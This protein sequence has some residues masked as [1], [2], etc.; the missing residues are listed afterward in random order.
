MKIKT[1]LKLIIIATISMLVWIICLQLWE[2]K[3]TAH[4]NRQEDSIRELS[5]DIFLSNQ[6]REE[7]FIYKTERAKQQWFALDKQ[8]TDKC[9]KEMLPLFTEASEKNELELFMRRHK[10]I[11]AL[12]KQLILY[13]QA[14]TPG[15]ATDEIRSIIINQMTGESHLQYQQC[16]LLSGAIDKM[17]EKQM[18]SYSTFNFMSLGLFG[19][20]IIM[21]SR[22]LL[23]R[24]SD[25]LLQ[26]KEGTRIISE[27]NFGHRLN[28]ASSDEIG[29]LARDF[30]L[31]TEQLSA[32]TVS[33]D[34]MSEEIENRKKAEQKL[35]DKNIEME[36]FAY[37]V[38]HDL[39]SPLITIQA[40][41]GMIMNNLE[42]GKHDCIQDDM[43]RIEGAA[44]KMTNLLNDLLELSRVGVVMS[45]PA[46]IDMNLLVKDCL[47]LLT[48]PLKQKGVEVVVQP[49][50]PK[51]NGDRHRIT[52]VL[53]NLVE[54]AVKYMGEQAAPRIL[55]GTREN[56]PET[57]F[58]VAD[59]GS[60][61][62]PQHHD[63]IFGLFNKLDVK[64]QGTGVGLALVK[65]IIEVHGGRVWVE[66][67]GAGKG[68]TFC[69]TVPG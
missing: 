66:S 24:V 8:I 11:A 43:K 50:L 16:V 21:F 40:Y 54:N 27:G 4:L 62:D 18:A 28:V 25:P 31:M 52:E 22:M 67:E 68:S 12:F 35:Q 63:K 69:F 58:F 13:D 36:R 57:I 59:N 33:R 32:I 45:E 23:R 49:G 3:Q 46:Q 29:E 5:F 15:G 44:A 37:T 20:V 38:S 42:A 56:G 10:N 48:G 61:I 65:R 9:N 17:A 34:E 26:L 14:D 6:I 2:N 19:L 60:G 64:S 53:Q 30:D 39:K 41:A 51:I 47:A 7:Y 1:R 55:I